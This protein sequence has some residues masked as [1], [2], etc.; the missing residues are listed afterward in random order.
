MKILLVVVCLFVVHAYGLR[1]S[2]SS[3]SSPG[4]VVVNT[5]NDCCYDVCG[6]TPNPTY[7][8]CACSRSLG[9][10]MG[11]DTT[12]QHPKGGET[13]IAVTYQGVDTKACTA[14][15]SL[16]GYT[17][18]Q[19]QC[20]NWCWAASIA[21]ITAYYHHVM[22]DCVMDEVSLASARSH[23]ECSMP[24]NPCNKTGPD[25]YDC[26]WGATWPE[27][28][29]GMKARNPQ[30]RQFW[31]Q[32]APL[33]TQQLADTI[34]ARHPVL[35]GVEPRPPSVHALSSHPAAAR[36]VFGLEAHIV[37]IAGY[38]CVAWRGGAGIY[39]FLVSDPAVGMTA[40]LEYAQLLQYTGKQWTYTLWGSD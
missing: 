34:E 19:Q 20:S 10:C 39:Q 11:C 30:I 24:I 17:W 31:D 16:E 5:T 35:I 14:D 25:P 36:V 2:S 9:G 7:T 18:C 29:D 8:C 1:L 28:V 15:L 38:R 13:C 33:T 27:I 37:V 26:N 32:H 23:R 22:P 40:W 3:S 12:A 21:T 4:A 6:W